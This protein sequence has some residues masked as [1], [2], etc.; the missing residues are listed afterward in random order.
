MLKFAYLKWKTFRQKCK[1]GSKWGKEEVSIKD[2]EGKTTVNSTS[3]ERGKRNAKGQ[4][5]ARNQNGRRA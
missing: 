5:F 2:L 3:G 1:G 4:C